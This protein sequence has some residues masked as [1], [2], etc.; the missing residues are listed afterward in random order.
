MR[1]SLPDPGRCAQTW[2]GRTNTD[3]TP[4]RKDRLLTY[5]RSD[6]SLRSYTCLPDRPRPLCDL[7]DDQLFELHGCGNSHLRSIPGEAAL[8][9][10][11]LEASR[12]LLVE[13]AHDFT[14]RAGGRHQRVV[15][16]DV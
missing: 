14:A 16:L 3:P 8:H 1:G 12:D 5:R 2:R 11:R 15:L 13:T 4:A 7:A 9:V 10:G 6:D